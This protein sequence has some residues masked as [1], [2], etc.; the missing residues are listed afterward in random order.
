MAKVLGIDPGANCGW[1]VLDGDAY[2]RGGTEKFKMPTA[3]QQRKGVPRGQKWLDFSNWAQD[4][5]LFERPDMVVVEDVRR[6]ASTL[7]AH[8]YGFYRYTL[9]SVCAS[10]AVPFYPIGVG[11]WKKIATDSGASGK[12]AIMEQIG[13]V[14]PDIQFDSDD[15]SDAVG[16]AFA[17]RQLSMQEGALEALL[18]TVGGKRKKKD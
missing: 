14:F 18:E 10:R 5:V 16:I 6:H 11:V 7:A 15:H 4:L 3:A 1:A 2:T 13:D 9:E 8:S 12:K 17:A